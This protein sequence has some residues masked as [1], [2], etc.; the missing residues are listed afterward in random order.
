MKIL[1]DMDGVLADFTRQQGLEMIRQG[2]PALADAQITEFYAERCY[3]RHFGPDA[4][5]LAH[6]IP[7][8]PG[9]FRKLPLIMGAEAGVRRLQNAGF[10]VQICSKPITGHPTCAE[11]KQ[12]WLEEHFGLDL[13]ETAYIGAHKATVEADYLIDDRPNILSYSRRHDRTDPVW[14]PIRFVQPWNQVD[15]EARLHLHGWAH[16]DSLLRQLA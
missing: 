14:A 4:L 8:R 7:N 11:E 15:T 2:Y 12:E 3:G 5:A 10:T 1:V 9:F 13:A 16:L 6:D